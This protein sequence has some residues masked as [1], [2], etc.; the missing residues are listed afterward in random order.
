MSETFN[1]DDKEK[2]VPGN[3][4]DK[5]SNVSS[6]LT[7]VDLVNTTHPSPSSTGNLD[8]KL[9]AT[10]FKSSLKLIQAPGRSLENKTTN[11][12]N[13]VTHANGF[14]PDVQQR[15]NVENVN[16]VGNNKPST[17]E[18]A[19]RRKSSKKSLQLES[20]SLYR[21]KKDLNEKEDNK[22]SEH[23]RFGIN[24]NAII[25]KRTTSREAIDHLQLSSEEPESIIYQFHDFAATLPQHFEKIDS[26][27]NEPTYSHQ[28]I[29]SRSL[30]SR[31]KTPV[32]KST[33]RT[34]LRQSRKNSF[35]KQYALKNINN[36]QKRHFLSLNQNNENGDYRVIDKTDDVSSDAKTKSAIP[37]THYVTGDIRTAIEV[38]NPVKN[39]FVSHSELPE[40]I[41]TD[42]TGSMERID[43]S[44]MR[45][46]QPES[47]SP[48]P[49]VSGPT[50]NGL[51][52]LQSSQIG[53]KTTVFDLNL[54]S[55][56]KSSILQLPGTPSQVETTN[57]ISRSAK[58]FK[59]DDKSEESFSVTPF[60]PVSSDGSPINIPMMSATDDSIM[61]ATSKDKEPE[62]GID[63]APSKSE[64]SR[65]SA[66]NSNPLT[67][68]S[69][70][71]KN[72]YKEVDTKWN[73]DLSSHK[74]KPSALVIKN[75]KIRSLGRSLL[76]DA[77]KSTSSDDSKFDWLFNEKVDERKVEDRK[78][79]KF[80][81][82]ENPTE[83]E[84]NDEI[85]DDRDENRAGKTFRDSKDS[86]LISDIIMSKEK[87]VDKILRE[88]MHQYGKNSRKTEDDKWDE[89]AQLAPVPNSKIFDYENDLGSEKEGRETPINDF[90]PSMPSDVNSYG[91]TV[92]GEYGN[93]QYNNPEID[94]VER[95][96]NNNHHAHRNH[97]E[98]DYQNSRYNDYKHVNLDDRSSNHRD[99]INEDDPQFEILEKD[100]NHHH[101]RPNNDLNYEHFD[102]SHRSR[103]SDEN[104][105]SFHEVHIKRNKDVR[106][107]KRNNEPLHENNLESFKKFV[108]E[109][110][111]NY[112]GTNQDLFEAKKM[113]THNSLKS[114][115]EVRRTING[116]VHIYNSIVNEKNG[117]NKNHVHKFK[118]PLL[119]KFERAK[120]RSENHE[121]LDLIKEALKYLTLQNE[122]NT[123]LSSVK[124]TSKSDLFYPARLPPKSWRN[125]FNEPHSNADYVIN[126][127][128]T[129]S[130]DSKRLE[131]ILKNEVY[132]DAILEITNLLDSKKNKK[133]KKLKVEQNSKVKNLE[134][135]ELALKQLSAAAEKNT[136]KEYEDFIRRISPYLGRLK[137]IGSKINKSDI[138]ENDKNDKNLYSLKNN[139]NAKVD[140]EEKLNATNVPLK[141]GKEIRPEE[142]ELELDKVA[143]GASNLQETKEELITALEAAQ[144][145]SQKHINN[146][147]THKDVASYGSLLHFSNA[148]NKQKDNKTTPQMLRGDNAPPD[149]NVYEAK[150]SSKLTNLNKTSSGSLNIQLKLLDD[151]GLAPQPIPIVEN[152][153][154]DISPEKITLHQNKSAEESTI[155]SN[156]ILGKD[157]AASNGHTN[158]H[159][160]LTP[161]STENSIQAS[162]SLFKTPPSLIQFSKPNYFDTNSKNF[163]NKNCDPIADGVEIPY[164]PPCNGL[165]I[166]ASL[167]PAAYT[168]SVKIRP[169]N[170]IFNPFKVGISTVLP[171]SNYNHYRPNMQTA[172]NYNH[173]L[174]NMQT[175]AA[176]LVNDHRVPLDFL[177][178]FT[179]GTN[180]GPSHPTRISPMSLDTILL[181]EA[182]ETPTAVFSKPWGGSFREVRKNL[183]NFYPV[184]VPLS[185]VSNSD[186][187]YNGLV[188]NNPIS[189]SGNL[190]EGN[191]LL[192][193][194]TVKSPSL[195]KVLD[196]NPID[197]QYK[198]PEHK[199]DVKNDNLFRRGKFSVIKKLP[200]IFKF[201]DDSDLIKNEAVTRKNDWRRD[202]ETE[203]GRRKNS[204]EEKIFLE[205]ESE[206]NEGVEILEKNDKKD[207]VRLFAQKEKGI[208]FDENSSKISLN[209]NASSATVLHN[210]TEEDFS[211]DSGDLPEIFET[212]GN[213]EDD[214]QFNENKRV[215]KEKSGKTY[216]KEVGQNFPN[217]AKVDEKEKNSSFYKNLPN[218]KTNQTNSSGKSL[219][220]DISSN[221]GNKS[222]AKTKNQIKKGLTN[223]N[224]HH[225]SKKSKS[226]EVA[227]KNNSTLYDHS[228]K[229]L[230]SSHTIHKYVRPAK[231]NYKHQSVELFSFVPCGLRTGIKM[232][233]DR[234]P[235]KHYSYFYINFYIHRI[236]HGYDLTMFEDFLL[237]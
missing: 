27:L 46:P 168:E 164:V 97:E 73:P 103:S 39:N 105:A 55:A 6:I 234:P 209:G 1:G 104:R 232:I 205:N 75:S 198:E 176:N 174:P 67:K 4:N 108:K 144:A 226:D 78:D 116:L 129:G 193:D 22:K 127:Y 190:L 63:V 99:D 100:T 152:I 202:F 98:E 80:K 85:D 17:A 231:S 14:V 120:K 57:P 206:K 113:H 153:K 199:G 90:H 213:P 21:E 20:V 56:G 171:V 123:R 208:Y 119:L 43:I 10:V 210:E 197:N 150:T 216:S 29:S 162:E 124:T 196:S 94:D 207:E 228:K 12:F 64:L 122:K 2:K 32:L 184:T 186:A 161:L 141:S 92:S 5:L 215:I 211:G 156:T 65:E 223:K 72:I 235:G 195:Y 203:I 38:P 117:E 169:I 106:A 172:V 128:L 40:I 139:Q 84:E 91:A 115:R 42:G 179:T 151:I 74:V 130:D 158:E 96:L 52:L 214:S 66:V 81:F 136:S 222:K 48:V 218:D 15:N 112:A 212:S 118:S 219:K 95:V 121:R 201:F 146:V 61:T 125:R 145:I 135:I 26:R 137:E 189:E 126:K 204:F 87:D 167:N 79:R 58:T 155:I 133:N 165:N 134:T 13:T 30:V 33:K 132:N 45:A 159:N 51:P 19:D 140:F 24:T 16:R 111:G 36:P 181:N 147:E 229:Q 8:S 23:Q 160:E 175:A 49:A 101:S 86:P 31:D 83:D 44:H 183:D 200:V 9:I 114:N 102:H 82:K 60:G 188:S 34:L 148:I 7:H 76:S 69:P 59:L 47:F 227:Q 221:D 138:K 187:L 236:F 68:E 157:N 143:D 53:S 28:L 93:E 185:P 50:L 110:A 71:H 149:E 237:P 224:L 230:K 178:S 177:T 173:Y 154:V 131:H 3:Y 54:S 217:K 109:V 88:E 142:S 225:F 41:G 77:R 192:T 191:E 233:C 35:K 18:A 37:F 62:M 180:Y 163:Y 182:T 89:E 11:D 25:H 170:H 194:K 107:N 220:L 166:L 70:L